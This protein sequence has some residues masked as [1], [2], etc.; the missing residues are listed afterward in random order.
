MIWW[1]AGTLA[2]IIAL[3]IKR[4]LT[5]R[6]PWLRPNGRNIGFPIPFALIL[7]RPDAPDY[8]AVWA[9][10]VCEGVAYRSGRAWFRWRWDQ[11]WRWEAELVGK[12]VEAVAAQLLYGVDRQVRIE[13]EAESLRAYP[14]FRHWPVSLIVRRMK[15]LEP[16]AEAWVDRHKRAI[17]KRYEAERQRRP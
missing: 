2:A 17:W 5:I 13:R 12:T 11:S 14:A 6:W 4:H 3:C 1:A 7:M 9:Q 10:E 8:A 15:D 16:V